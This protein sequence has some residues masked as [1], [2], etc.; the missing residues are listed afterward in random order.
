MINTLRALWISSLLKKNLKLFDGTSKK[1]V[2]EAILGKKLH[3]QITMMK[4]K[5][6][7]AKKK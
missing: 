7:K 3:T 2:N 1:N 5:K 4:E 6:A